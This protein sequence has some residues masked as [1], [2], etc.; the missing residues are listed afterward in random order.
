LDAAMS[1]GADVVGGIDPCALDRDPVGHLDVVFGVAERHHRGVDL[2]LHEPGELGAFT[3][4]LIAQRT[5]ALGMQGLVTISHAFALSTV[6]GLRQGALV[7]VLAGN[8]LA[9][10]TVAPGA[11]DPLPIDRLRA[12]GVRVGLGQDGIR[13]FWSP[14]GNGDMLE[15]AWQLAFRAGLRRDEHIEGCVDVASRGGRA[16]IGGHAW[17]SVPLVDDAQTGLAVGAP[18]DLVVVPA[19]TVTSA[20]MDHPP[21]TLV[22]HAGRVVAH[23]GALT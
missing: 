18:A 12:A 22:I 19:E 11:R 15:R 7:E 14:Y 17:S 1:S 16:C 23:D 9:L 2:H 6:D 3:I 13:D 10:T 20:V 4:E 8:D 21:R 5:A